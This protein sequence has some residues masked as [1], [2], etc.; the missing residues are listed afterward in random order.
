MIASRMSAS[1]MTGRPPGRRQLA[2]ACASVRP[3]IPSLSFTRRSGDRAGQRGDAS[4]TLGP[5]HLEPKLPREW[6][7][8]INRPLGDRPEASHSAARNTQAIECFLGY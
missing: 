6:T 3:W 2:P 8:P 5:V 1:A 4:E 7:I